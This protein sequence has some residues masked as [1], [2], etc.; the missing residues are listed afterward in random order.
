MADSAAHEEHKTVDSHNDTQDEVEFSVTNLRPQR[1]RSTQKRPMRTDERRWRWA[2]VA[3]SL[4]IALAVVLSSLPTAH[5]ALGRLAGLVFPTPTSNIQ[6]I[7]RISSGPIIIG[8]IELTP[9]PL[10]TASATPQLGRAC[11]LPPAS[12]EA[13]DSWA[14]AGQSH[15]WTIRLGWRVH[16]RLPDAFIAA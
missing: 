5:D 1:P 9:A 8:D 7:S 13:T 15:W 12:S 11:E 14:G 3:L 10:P 4:V 2:A 16:R 6:L